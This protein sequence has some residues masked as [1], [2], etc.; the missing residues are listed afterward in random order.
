MAATAQIS[1]TGTDTRERIVAA[2][3]EVFAENGFDG[4]TTRDIAARAGVN[5]GLIKYYFDSKLKLWQAAVDRA[6]SDLRTALAQ[7]D[8]EAVL[9]ESSRTRELVRGYVRFV[10][11]NPEFVRIMHDEGKRRGPRMRWL[12]DHHVRPLYDA[13][14]DL[15]RGAQ[16]RGMLPPRIDPVHLMYI[17]AGAAGLFFHQAEEVRRLS[18]L[19]PADEKVIEA[20]ADAVARILLGPETTS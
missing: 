19:D 16:Q 8:R 20:H 13:I 7:I 4:S 11:H 5:L 10:A 14:K 2:A 17:L 6:F 12:A 1:A 3:L 9:D 18:A 15:L